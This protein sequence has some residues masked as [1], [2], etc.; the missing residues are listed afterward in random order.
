MKD[1]FTVVSLHPGFV[2]SDMGRAAGEGASRSA[3]GTEPVL[4]A[5]ESVSGMLKVIANLMPLQSGRFIRYD[6]Q[7]MPW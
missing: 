6:G 1:G 7:D 2:H 3:P 5:N 4:S